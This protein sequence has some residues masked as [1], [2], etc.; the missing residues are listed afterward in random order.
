MVGLI[1]LGL[2][3]STVSVC[4]PSQGYVVNYNKRLRS[5]ANMAYYLEDEKDIRNAYSQMLRGLIV[6]CCTKEP[7]LRPK[8]VEL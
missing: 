6:E 5:G 2:L 3:D 1:M 8:A 4:M 7:L